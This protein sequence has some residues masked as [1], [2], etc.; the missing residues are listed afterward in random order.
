MKIYN[1]LVRDKI[2]EIIKNDNKKFDSHIVN[3]ETVLELLHKKLDEEVAEFHA[4]KNL[5]ELADILEVIF[6]LSKK[7]GYTED[8]LLNKRLEKREARGG[9]DQNIVLD[10]VYE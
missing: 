3:N 2:P 7:L 9:F 4:D 5:E 10:K 6:A 1:K 8:D